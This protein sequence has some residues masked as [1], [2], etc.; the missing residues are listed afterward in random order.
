MLASSSQRYVGENSKKS[1]VQSGTFELDCL[2]YLIW[3]IRYPRTALHPN[4]GQNPFVF[5][6]CSVEASSTS[7]REA[8]GCVACT[9]AENED[10]WTGEDEGW[11]E[12]LGRKSFSL[13]STARSRHAPRLIFAVII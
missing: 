2:R 1:I 3:N 9:E 5:A 13:F 10:D 7:T 6:T 8:G 11:Y 4:K 12:K